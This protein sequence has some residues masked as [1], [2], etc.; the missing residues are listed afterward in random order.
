MSRQQKV[1]VVLVAYLFAIAL[2]FSLI[3]MI[4]TVTSTDPPV[5]QGLP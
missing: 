4:P 5:P 2:I 3:C 1:L